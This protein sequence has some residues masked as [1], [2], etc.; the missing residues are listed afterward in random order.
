[1]WDLR[2]RPLMHPPVNYSRTP[3]IL[4]ASCY[5]WD[6][7]TYFHCAVPG[8]QKP[9]PC[10]QVS[11]PNNNKQ[12]AGYQSMPLPPPFHVCGFSHQMTIKMLSYH[13]LITG[14]PKLQNQGFTGKWL[15]LVTT[16]WTNN[17]KQRTGYHQ[18]YS[19]SVWECA[20]WPVLYTQPQFLVES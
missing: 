2:R 14:V 6:I 10:H 15:G 18:T 8:T 9:T 12:G 16:N 1:M 3:V 5:R 20:E 19:H 11:G 13:I 4:L 7:P 17:N